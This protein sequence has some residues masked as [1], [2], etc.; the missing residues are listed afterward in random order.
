MMANEKPDRKNDFL[1]QPSSEELKAKKLAKAKL[2]RE[3]KLAKWREEE[4]AKASFF[5][6]RSTTCGK[7]DS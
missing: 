1:V 2:D 5:W 3:K 6:V 4:K 7:Y